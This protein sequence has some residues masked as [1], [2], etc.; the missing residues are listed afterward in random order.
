MF[1]CDRAQVRGVRR[2][3]R[4]MQPRALKCTDAPHSRISVENRTR[5]ILPSCRS[6][7]GATYYCISIRYQRIP[8][9]PTARRTISSNVPPS[10]VVENANFCV[11]NRDEQISLGLL[12]S[13]LKLS[14]VTS[15][16]FVRII[17]QNSH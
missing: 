5:T 2:I 12:S 15:L 9:A 1:Y 14:S 10:S 6:R 3:R 7:R 8:C 16:Y 4:N 11:F 17:C 13:D